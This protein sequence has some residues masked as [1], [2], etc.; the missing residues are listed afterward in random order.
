MHELL[1]FNLIKSY[2][3]LFLDLIGAIEV[4]LKK[5]DKGPEATCRIPLITSQT[6]EQLF[7]SSS[8]KVLLSLFNITSFINDFQRKCFLK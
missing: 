3:F 8:A 7:L 2:I 4:A 6:E 1:Y 5:K